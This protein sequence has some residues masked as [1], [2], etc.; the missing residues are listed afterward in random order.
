MAIHGFQLNS[1]VA[2][3]QQK[4]TQRFLDAHHRS[5]IFSPESITERFVSRSLLL[6]A[7]RPTSRLI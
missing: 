7:S 4:A 6:A 3:I 1:I 5:T 2:R